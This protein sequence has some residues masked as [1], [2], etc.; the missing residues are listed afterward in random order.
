MA[1]A[2]SFSSLRPRTA[3]LL[4]LYKPETAQHC[5]RFY[6][7]DAVVVENVSYLAGK[8]LEA[9]NSSI[10]VATPSHLEAIE[11]RLADFGLNLDDMRKLRRYFVLDAARTLRQFLSD[12]IPDPARFDA[13]V[14][15][16]MREAVATSADSFVF[17][18]GEMVSL[19]CAAQNSEAALCLERLW[20]SL[21]RECR[22]SLYCAYSLESFGPEPDLDAIAQICSEH[23]LAV[24]AETFP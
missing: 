22:F 3:E 4:R 11:R 1:L 9:G 14:G 17:A 18:F 20:N 13:V 6:E 2:K 24:A 15:G 8:A 23:H 12:G 16:V 10:V 21:A 5:V 19:L 7:C